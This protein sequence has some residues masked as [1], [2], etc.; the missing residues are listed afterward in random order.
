MRLLSRDPSGRGTRGSAQMLAALLFLGIASAASAQVTSDAATQAPPPRRGHVTLRGA[1]LSGFPDVVGV[2]ATLTAT[3]PLEVEVGLSTA[4]FASSV[5]ARAGYAFV[6]SDGRGAEGR[7]WTVDL[8]PMLGWRYLQ[9]I[10][11]DVSHEI[12]A[13]SVT[14]ALDAT[15]WASPGFGIALQLTLGGDY[16]VVHDYSSGPP[17]LLIPDLRLAV[18]VAL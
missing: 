7:G 13:L 6:L 3:A 12:H 17:T 10:P 4:L 18:G 15:F 8:V 2:A 14:G 9:T 5:Y 11:F 1:L 16:Y